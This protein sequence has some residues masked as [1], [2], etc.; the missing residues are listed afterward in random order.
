MKLEHKNSFADTD[1]MSD[2]E[3]INWAL[4]QAEIDLRGYLIIGGVFTLIAFIIYIAS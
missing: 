1:N 3:L 2:E 4:K